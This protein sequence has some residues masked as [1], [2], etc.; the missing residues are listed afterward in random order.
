MTLPTVRD[1]L[2]RAIDDL[3]TAGVPEPRADAEIVLA[4]TLG[5]DRVYL[6][7]HGGDVVP[8]QQ[9]DEYMSAVES[10]RK[11]RPLSYITGAKEFFG[12]EFEVSQGVM[13]PRPETELLVE[14]VISSLKESDQPAGRILDIGTGCGNIAVS[15]ARHISSAWVVGTDV[16]AQA[17]AV[18][19]RNALRH[20]VADRVA[21][22]VCDIVSAVRGDESFDAIV[23]NPPYIR[24]ADIAALLPE[25]GEHEPR[26][27]LDGGLDGLSAIGRIAAS[28]PQYLKG[29]GIL[30]LEIGEGQSGP[31]GALLETA[32]FGQVRIVPDYAG[33]ARL[34]TA[35]KPPD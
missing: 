12:L 30:A 23:S 11:R 20:G 16:S 4:H 17:V 8:P 27:A 21:F 24:T 33:I 31:V 6:L 19:A 9:A 1:L 18:A 14:E 2:A 25:V 34:V 10:R 7:A 3:E 32:G 22:I 5:R 26:I 13:V 15:L 35:R 29:G 28:A